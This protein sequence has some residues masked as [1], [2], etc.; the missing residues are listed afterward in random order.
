MDHSGFLV[1]EDRGI[2]VGGVPAN[3]RW[4]MAGGDLTRSRPLGNATWQGLM[5]GTPARGSGK[6][7]RLQGNATLTYDLDSAT[8]D[9][10]FTNIQNVDRLQPHSVSAVRFD[11]INVSDRG[12]FQAG[13]S[14]NQIQG[15]FYGPDHAETAGVFEQSNIIGAF[16]AKKQ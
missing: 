16:G 7:Q 14:D 2:P 3:M 8:L 10:A 4:N 11:N 13:S 9:A 15:G 1:Q 6:G 5:V 12:T